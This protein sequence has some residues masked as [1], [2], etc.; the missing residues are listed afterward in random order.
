MKKKNWYLLTV[1][2][3][4]IL[5]IAGIYSLDE[6][7]LKKNSSRIGIQSLMMVFWIAFTIGNILL[8]RNE[9]RKSKTQ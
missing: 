4:F 6:A 9:I 5:I 3:G 8:Y 1:F 7:I 2:I